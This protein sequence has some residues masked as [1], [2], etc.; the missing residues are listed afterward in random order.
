MALTPNQITLLRVA[1]AFASVCLY[2]KHAWA[3]LIAVSLTVGAIALDGLDG[4]IARKRQLATPFGAQLDVLGDR[5]IENVYFTYFAVCGLVSLW[6]PVLFFARGTATDFIRSIAA[7]AGH[8]G[9]GQASMMQTWWGR[10]LVASRWSRG[11][12]AAMK[13]ACFCYL[14]LQLAL[15]RGPVALVS[16]LSANTLGGIW[17]GAQAIIWATA[18]LCVVRGLPVIVEGWRHVAA[19]AAVTGQPTDGRGMAHT[20]ERVSGR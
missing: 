7:N 14:G 15:A 20:A 10:A 16:Q 13:C 5:V 8:S 18:A 17:V 1:V 6:L 9:W 3:N 11:A 4:Y 2:G 12:Y 19:Y